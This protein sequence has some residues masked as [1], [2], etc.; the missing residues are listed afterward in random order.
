LEAALPRP[1][2]HKL[3]WTNQYLEESEDSPSPVKKKCRDR[4]GVSGK[5]VTIG[6][7]ASGLLGE[8]LAKK[9]SHKTSLVVNE[10]PVI[11]P[12]ASKNE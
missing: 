2:G 12:T 11:I 3:T 7:R 10:C 8:G 4:M 6:S 1:Q 5:L 9:V